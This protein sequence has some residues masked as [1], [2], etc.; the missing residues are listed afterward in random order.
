MSTEAVEHISVLLSTHFLQAVERACLLFV[1][2]PLTM[3][4]IVL[5]GE[6][7]VS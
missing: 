4:G 1:K 5:F 3:Y 7:L 2:Y 6:Y